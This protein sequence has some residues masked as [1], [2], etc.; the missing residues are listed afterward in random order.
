MTPIAK[1]ALALGS[2]VIVVIGVPFVM[3]N[4]YALSVIVVTLLYAYLALSW[5]VIGGI[6]GQLSLGHAAWFGIGAYTS[7]VL[8]LNFGVS[9][10]IGM[11][12]GAALSAAIATIV[13]VPCFKLRG[14]Y[15]ALATIAA[16]MV[17]RIVVENTHEWLGGPR[18]LGVTLLHDAP[19]YFQHTRKEFYYA[20]AVALV[21]AALGVNFAILRSRFGAY[22]TAIRN[23]QEAA[24]ALGVEV[25]R[26]KLL[27]FVVSAAMTAIGGTFYAQFVLF[28]SPE[29]VF[30]VVISIQIAVTCIIGG[31][32]TL[33]GPLLGAVLLLVGEELARRI[34]GGMVGA[35]SMLYGLLLMAVV[36]VEPRGVVALVPRLLRR[37]KG[38]EPRPAAMLRGG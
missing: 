25:Q 6:A 32:G 16:T 5:N 12:A 38:G 34:T 10:W 33:W 28:I 9:P 29:K 35:D 18:G 14:A 4:P 24:L 27:A 15:F 20:V 1:R 21:V 19:L 22:L 8:F 2:A 30:G 3:S 17:L 31:R 13:G 11:L 36:M 26:C 23:D 7:T 37:V